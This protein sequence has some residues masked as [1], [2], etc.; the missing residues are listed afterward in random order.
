MKKGIIVIVGVLFLATFSFAQIELTAFGLYNLNLSYPSDVELDSDLESAMPI[1]YPEWQAFFEDS[2]TQK[3]GLGF[4][5]RIAFNITPSIGI[6]GSFEYIM[7]ESSFTEG[8]LDDAVDLMESL[9]YGD[10]VEVANESGGN[11]M[12]YYG[13]IVF[14]IPS[15]GNMTPYITA[16]LGITQF[17]LAEGVGPEIDVIH[18]PSGQQ[19]HIYYTDTSALTFNGGLG[20]KALL[21]SNIGVRIDARVFY[22]NPEF[23][24]KLDLEMFWTTVFDGLDSVLQSGA[25]MDANLNVGFFARF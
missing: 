1:F 11:I 19:V 15:P 6:E 21:A 13:N 4:G 18:S 25:H 3:G 10:A 12:R 5:G 22:C 16:G 17:K 7:A 2:L 23:Q 14:N 9:G 24:Q 20:I 8:I